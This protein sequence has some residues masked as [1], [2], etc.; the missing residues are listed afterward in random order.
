[1]FKVRRRCLGSSRFC[2]CSSTREAE[3]QKAEQSIEVTHPADERAVSLLVM[4]QGFT[5][6]SARLR[7]KPQLRAYSGVAAHADQEA[8]ICVVPLARVA[9]KSR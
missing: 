1:M 5:V 9:W 2:S 7:R 6:S 3:E 4:Q 8:E